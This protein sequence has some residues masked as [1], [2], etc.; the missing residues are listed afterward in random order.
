MLT[1]A[2]LIHPFLPYYLRQGV[3]LRQYTAQF[4]FICYRCS[5]CFLF[6]AEIV[7][8]L[9][10]KT[11][12]SKCTTAGCFKNALGKFLLPL[13]SKEAFALNLRRKDVH[14]SCGCPEMCLMFVCVCVCVCF[15]LLCHCLLKKETSFFLDMFAYSLCLL[16]FCKQDKQ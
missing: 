15:A 16:H 9:M 4:D 1:L 7:I 5:L 3:S 6:Y 10:T 12:H 13:Q 14:F 11:L 8:W 2:S